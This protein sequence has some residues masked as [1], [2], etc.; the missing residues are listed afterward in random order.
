MNTYKK[1]NTDIQ[2]KHKVDNKFKRLLQIRKDEKRMWTELVHRQL[3][4]HRV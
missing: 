3:Q 2:D 4:I 1:R